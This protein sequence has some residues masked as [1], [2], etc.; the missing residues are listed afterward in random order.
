MLDLDEELYN[1][2]TAAKRPVVSGSKIAALLQERAP[3][4]AERRFQA[5]LLVKHLPANQ[6]VEV[7]K[8]ALKDAS[9]EVRLFAF[10]RIEKFRADLEGKIKTFSIDLEK[11]EERDKAL[12][13]LRLAES[14]HEIAYLKL[15]EGAVLDHALDQALQHALEAK[16]LQP[17]SGPAEYLLGR[18]LL[19]KGDYDR[20][21]QSFQ[22]AVRLYYPRTKVIPYLAEC[23]FRQKRYDAVRAMLGEMGRATRGTSVLQPLV[24]FWR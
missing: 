13:H 24:D 3:E 14:F 15:A 7:L 21:V 9:D 17:T 19:R 12:L 20:A 22:G 11:A 10:S 23:A 6:Q 5:I 16:R 1:E 18:I 8:I 4:H 2:P